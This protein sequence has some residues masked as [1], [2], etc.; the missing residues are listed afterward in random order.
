MRI[1]GEEVRCGSTTSAGRSDAAYGDQTKERR[2]RLGYVIGRVS[3]TLLGP[4]HLLGRESKF[5]RN[6]VK[7]KLGGEVYASSEMMD[8]VALP[9]DCYAPLADVPPGIL[10]L[11]DCE[12]LFPLLRNKKAVAEK[13]RARHFLG[14]Q[15]TSDDG[16]LDNVFWLPAPRV[17]AGGHTEVKSGMAPLFRMPQPGSF[18]PSK[19]RP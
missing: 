7:S 5:A 4:R 8:H 19:L 2:C 17:P 16:G 9:Q 10:V 12:S 6:L 15:Q 1:R 3:S 14:I 13:C 11:E 18:G